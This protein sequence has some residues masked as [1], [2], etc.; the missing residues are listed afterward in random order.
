MAGKAASPCD[1][2]A[3]VAGFDEQRYR[4]QKKLLVCRY[5]LVDGFKMFS[6]H[7]LIRDCL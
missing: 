6:K 1:S 3:G 2:G 5:S 7:G 4:Q